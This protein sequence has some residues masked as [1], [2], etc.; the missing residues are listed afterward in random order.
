MRF[1]RS[2]SPIERGYLAT[3]PLVSPFAIQLVV[4]GEG[5]IDPARLRQAVAVASEAC[6]GA[7]LVKRAGLWVDSGRTPPV[8]VLPS[9]DL[10]S[11]ALRRP[12]DPSVGPLSEVLLVD[13]VPPAGGSAGGTGTTTVLLRAAHVAMDASGTLGWAADIFRALRGEPPV[14]ARSTLTDNGLRHRLTPSPA[15]LSTPL[16]SRS[17]LVGVT[18]RRRHRWRRTTVEGDRHAL[19]ARM[20]TATVTAIGEPSR[21]MVPVDLRRHLSGPAAPTGP[22]SENG[23]ALSTEPRSTGN[24]SLPVF[25]D[26]APGQPWEEV[27]ELL[28][29]A[30]AQRRELAVSAAEAWATWLP[31]PL[32]RAGL[33]AA[34]RVSR[35]WNRALCSVAVSDL[36]R[37]DPTEFSA[38]TFT[39][40]TVY[41]LPAYG[42]FVPVSFSTTRL[43]G[44][45]E[46]TMSYPAGVGVGAGAGAGADRAAGALLEAVAVGLT[47]RPPRPSAVARTAPVD[48]GRIPD[49]P[50]RTPPPTVGRPAP[51]VVELFLR[52]VRHSPDAVALTGPAGAVSYAELNQRA[53]VVAQRLHLLGVGPET[54][55]GLLTDRTPEGIAGLWGIL[56]AGAAYLPLDPSYPP[57]RLAFM[58]EDAN[59]ALCL[60]QLP[61]ADRLDGWSGSPGGG[62]VLA[63]EDLPPAGAAVPPTLPGPTDLAYVIYTSGSTGQPKGVQVEHRNLTAYAAWATPRYR[64]NSRT[65]FAL[66]TSLAFDLAG[67]ALFLPLLAGG[68]VEL[69]PGTPTPPA[70]RRMLTRGDVNALKLTPTHLDLIDRLG[71]RATG[72]RTVVVGGEQLRTTVAAQAQ[73][74]FGPE[75]V[76]VN[77]YGPTEATIGCVTGTFE[78]GRDDP[79]GAVPIGEPVPG[80]G[81]LLL[82]ADGTPVAPGAVGEIHL[83]GE[84]LARGYLNRPE[85]DR[86]RF[87]RLP[88]GERAYRTGDLARLR[89]D[90]LLEYV[91]RV[92]DQVKVRGYRIEPG[93]I[94][95]GLEEHPAVTRAVVLADA[96]QL[97]AY[98]TSR[99]PV[100]EAELRT[101][102]VDLLPPYLVPATILVVDGF[103]LTPNGKIDTVRLA[104]AAGPGS[105][106]EAYGVPGEAYGV[107]V[108]LSSEAPDPT[109]AAV[110]EVWS[111]V[112][113]T[114]VH[115]DSPDADFHHLGG[116]SL[117]LLNMLDQIFRSVGNVSDEEFVSAMRAVIAAP[118]L[119]TVSRLLR[120]AR[121]AHDPAPLPARST[122]TP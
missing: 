21:V 55:V 59:A 30:L 109:L 97:H 4:E 60:T 107:P 22:T 23:P 36:G 58:L 116:D 88:D 39:A 112:L 77:E 73:R 96:N 41:S 102:L 33:S 85:L 43:P 26:V 29:Y 31:R 69:V 32:L 46:L 64:V 35:R 92:D 24:L 11:D 65:R 13:G 19:V 45:I 83:T 3:A 53:D 62:S 117:T 71:V 47:T 119:G 27:H 120:E 67:T 80:T 34:E 68:S 70:L 108:E 75:C 44:R 17:P 54:V 111:R 9:L 89:T 37:V 78:A 50:T 84:Q 82:D 110:A 7:R 98:L 121:H 113:R 51:T 93:E 100:T 76:I 49:G 61:Y 10:D 72:V 114:T 18:A 94:A 12:F 38:D 95:S 86:D 101:H 56:K 63:L 20:A 28:L 57:K 118:T 79:T 122:P 115:P 25:L 48:R 105:T 5:R 106:G 91:G 15:R 2:V 14:G 87:V 66:F 8:T 40:G 90:A 6:P 81:V 74:I 16:R 1:T 99:A 103:P 52:R 104:Q 42:P